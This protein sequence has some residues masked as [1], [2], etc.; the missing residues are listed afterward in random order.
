MSI[1]AD[2]EVLPCG[3]N[4]VHECLAEIKKSGLK[5]KTGATGTTVE[6]NTSL[7]SPLRLKGAPDEVWSLLRRVHDIVAHR[8]PSGAFTDIKL[9]QVPGW[10]IDTMSSNQ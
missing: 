2:I 9:R 3:N 6:G 7:I 5:F 4:V 8:V 1:I 10:S